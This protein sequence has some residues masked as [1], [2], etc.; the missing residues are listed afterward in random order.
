MVGFKNALLAIPLLL[1]FGCATPGP[2]TYLLTPIAD[3]SPAPRTCRVLSVVPNSPAEKADFKRDD[4]IVA[5]NG[6]R[7]DSVVDFIRLVNSAADDMQADILREGTQK[8]ISLRLANAKPR[9]GILCNMNGFQKVETSHD[10]QT[11]FITSYAGPYVITANAWLYSNVTFVRVQ[12][13]N[14]S[15]EPI[16]IS[17][18]L[19]YAADGNRSVLNLLSPSQ[20]MQTLHGDV[21][22]TVAAAQTQMASANMAAQNARAN[23]SYTTTASAYSSGNYAYG[24]SHTTPDFGSQFSSNFYNGMAMGAAARAQQAVASAQADAAFLSQQSLYDTKVPPTF[25]GAGLVYFSAPQVMP[26]TLMADINGNKAS[27]RF[28]YLH[29]GS[30]STGDPERELL[31]R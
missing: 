17:P 10:G 4:E 26:F 8:R 2:R 16:Q 21:G 6:Q 1:I 25:S 11:K 23:T 7:P 24:E 22:A 31:G 14:A 19:F 28:N 9:L 3:G 13:Q 12:V 5:I 27:L 20:V 29:G 15:S 18:A 30:G